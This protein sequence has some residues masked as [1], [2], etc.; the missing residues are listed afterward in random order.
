[1]PPSELYQ[2]LC[3]VFDTCSWSYTEVSGREVIRAGFEA[4]HTRV[5]LH[6]Q[7]FAA[8]S[9][10]SVVAESSR[11]TTDPARRERLAEAV[12]RVNQSLT[13]GNFEL[14]WDL[15]RVFFRAT[16]LFANPAGDEGIISG[17]V[18]STVA[19]MDRFAPIEAVIHRATGSVLSS[20]DVA[21]LIRRDD[22]LPEVPEMETSPH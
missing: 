3:R 2:S 6:V 19:E 16:N 9:A 8:L 12:C 11:V 14:D 1:M 15:G 5:E 10:V 20:L 17:L 21:A 18:H 7:V 22:L 13:V 4:H